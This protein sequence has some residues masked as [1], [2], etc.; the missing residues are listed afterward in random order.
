[1]ANA[2]YPKTKAK[3]LQALIDLSDP[4]LDIK[5]VLVDTGQ[6][7]YSAAH[8]F[9]SDVPAGA[10]IAISDAL[11]NVT[12]DAD[13]AAFDSDDPIIAGVTGDTI[14]AIVLFVDTGVAAT[15]ALI[16]FQDTNITGAPLTPTGGNVQIFVDATGWFVL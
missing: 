15:S 8:E 11:V 7:T 13:T 5:A 1:M 9:L 6:Y 3:F 14:E 2:L 12:V 16:M 10:R 4:Y